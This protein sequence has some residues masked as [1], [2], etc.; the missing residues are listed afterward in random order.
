MTRRVR[1]DLAIGRLVHDEHGKRVGRIHDIRAEE[2]KGALLV[3]EYHLGGA[4]ML[5]K[6]GMVAR[7]LLGFSW[8]D[9]L[10]K[11]PWDRLDI[12][13]PER[14]RYLGDATELEGSA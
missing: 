7:R 5:E 12:S 8:K 1:L 13:D 3:V 6:W 14:P 2:E 10:I 4:A 11:V 9:N